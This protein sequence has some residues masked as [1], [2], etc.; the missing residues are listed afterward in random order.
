MDH[1]QSLSTIQ[2]LKLVSHSLQYK[3]Q[4]DVRIAHPGLSPGPRSTGACGAVLRS[5]CYYL[6]TLF[7]TVQ[8]AFTLWYGSVT[9][10]VHTLVRFSVCVQCAFTLGTVQCAFTLGPVQCAFTLGPVQ[11][12]FTLGPV[13]CAFDLR[14]SFFKFSEAQRGLGGMHNRPTPRRLRRSF[15]QLR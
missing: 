14:F 13:Q 11:C 7:G 10:C 5:C 12:A 2:A 1:G 6:F 8:C 3:V 15:S 4:L 9:V